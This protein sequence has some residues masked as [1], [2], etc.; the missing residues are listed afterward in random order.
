LFLN[1]PRI[2]NLIDSISATIGGLQT[3]VQLNVTFPS[4]FAGSS[5]G[6]G[7]DGR[8]S[9]TTSSF[10][11]KPPENFKGTVQVKDDP[12]SKREIKLPAS[13]KKVGRPIDQKGPKEET[14]T[15]APPPENVQK[16]P[17][18]HVFD[19][20][21]KE[22][23]MSLRF[24]DKDVASQNNELLMTIEC[25]REVFLRRM[26][27]D[28]FD[29]HDWTLTAGLDKQM[30]GAN[31]DI[32]VAVTNC[33]AFKNDYLPGAQVHQKVVAN[34]PLGHIVPVPWMPCGIKFPANKLSIDQNGI[35][36][37]ID[38]DGIGAGTS[39]ET[40]STVPVYNLDS[41]RGAKLGAD[42][43]K[44][45]REALSVYLQL[46]PT[47]TDQVPLL[48]RGLTRAQ[49]TW[50]GKAETVASYLRTHFEYSLHVPAPD[51]S[52]D[53][54]SHFLFKSKA[55]DC[56]HFASAFV[57]LM[58]SVGIPARVVGGYAPGA[59]SVVSG[60]IEIHSSDAHAWAEVYVPRFGWIPFDAVPDGYLPG[61][62]PDKSIVA[63]IAM[64][65]A[66]KS[67]KD[68]VQSIVRGRNEASQRGKAGEE[69][70]DSKGAADQPGGG[71]GGNDNKAGAQGGGKGN[72]SQGKEAQAI[73]GKNGKGDNSKAVEEEIAKASQFGQNSANNSFKFSL[74][75]L[76]GRARTFGNGIFGHEF[77]FKETRFD[78]EWFKRNWQPVAASIVM[79]PLLALLAFVLWKK[80]PLFGGRN[81]ANAA[82]LKPSTVE[83][84]KVLDD[85][86]KLKF[87]RAAGQTPQEIVDQV[88]SLVANNPD[89]AVK[90]H[91]PRLLEEF[92]DS[93]CSTRF[94]PE[95]SPA[96][97]A[98]LEQMGNKIHELVT[99]RP[100]SK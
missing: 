50:F 52:E 11:S 99:S 55:G 28:Y 4:G 82:E 25:A 16:A 1:L 76:A 53:L 38:G 7:P 19:D 83:F 9:A 90:A 44:K 2:E 77:A 58:R 81:K 43:E 75:G 71:T 32:F 21:T 22:E 56:S 57:V 29:G 35:I 14:K 13:Y 87:K 63:T 41:M 34:A 30:V 26:C 36:R 31:Q 84:L 51:K 85:L 73:G 8:G 66:V 47:T 100:D 64:S 23:G 94:A 89:E 3:P 17:P 5:G 42:E 15:E 93:Y 45:C 68:F 10:G 62:R 60:K 96:I 88:S 95:E 48:A 67:V 80:L 92:M 98:E 27:F 69:S 49:G 91:L 86:S 24:E 33:P 61:P 79:A 70:G 65:D 40:L 12:N 97:G 72:D 39:F 54:V 46:P 6:S 74:Q 20:L 59:R 78:F 18:G 37:A